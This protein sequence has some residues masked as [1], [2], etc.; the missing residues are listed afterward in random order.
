MRV[1]EVLRAGGPEVLV[2]GEREIPTPGPG[3][4]V[5]RSEYAGVNFADLWTR[6]DPT[7]EPRVVPGIEV[8]GFAHAVG[9]HVDGVAVGDR[10]V[11]LPYFALGGYA[12]FVE[13]PTTHV[14][15]VPDDVAF[16]L[17]AAM[18]VNY[19][20]A[21]IALARVAQVRRGE[22]VLVHAAAG[23]V[24]LA[25]VQLAAAAGATV[26]ATASPPKHD[27]LREQPGVEAVIDYNDPAWDDRVRD[28][29]GGGVDVVV[30]GIG[31]DGFRKSLHTLAF[32]GRLAAFGLTSA[33][34]TSTSPSVFES[35]DV[36]G[37]MIPFS[38]LFENAWSV[39]GVT[40]GAPPAQLA[41]WLAVLFDMCR[42]GEIHP[43]VGE[44]FALDRASDA[45]RAL[46]ERRN[47]GK[48]LL[49]VA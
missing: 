17:A 9:A 25:A 20:T 31:E 21:Y 35:L 8:A 27:F 42:S 5:I 46:H 6:L 34:T 26:V 19:L 11:G 12:E 36:E 13:V 7:S 47:V 3:N 4:V 49:E 16:E 18:P 44:R 14:L 29:S 10:V 33:M 41:E 23:G 28:V 39:G 15:P 22:R 38:P 48:L 32:G 2:V 24:G 30:D 40:G 1:V 43:H 45:H 37:L